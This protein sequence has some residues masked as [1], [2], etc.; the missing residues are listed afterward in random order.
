[1]ASAQQYKLSE[2]TSKN[3]TTYTNKLENVV[4]NE[5]KYY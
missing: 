3:Y 4:N 5:G 1:M 2:A